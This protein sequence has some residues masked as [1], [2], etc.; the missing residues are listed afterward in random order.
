MSKRHERLRELFLQEVTMALRNVNG[1]NDNGLLT[2]TG[3]EL[4]RDD[5]VFT[6]F[7]SVMGTPEELARKARV[8]AANSR[9]VRTTL[10]K[11]LRLRAVPEIVFKFDET[12]QK[13]AHIEKLLNK[14][15]SERP[16]PDEKS[17]TDE[18]P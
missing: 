15:K 16:D 8:L 11:R 10:F 3:A 7:Y 13:A 2:L 18:N 1:L 17:D 9:E 5:K 12:P 6:V 4:S 14:I